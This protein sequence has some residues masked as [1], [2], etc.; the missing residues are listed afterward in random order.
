M[1]EQTYK[2]TNIHTWQNKGDM[3]PFCGKL[4]PVGLEAGKSAVCSACGMDLK[5]LSTLT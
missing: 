2:H 5:V 1:A 4:Q 3:C